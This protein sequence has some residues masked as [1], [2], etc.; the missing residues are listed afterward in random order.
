MTHSLD[1]LLLIAA[2]CGIFYGVAELIALVRSSRERREGTDAWI[3]WGRPVFAAL[4]SG[5]VAFLVIR[6][7]VE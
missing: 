7:W 6:Q 3:D 2:A 5:F 4:V 1:I